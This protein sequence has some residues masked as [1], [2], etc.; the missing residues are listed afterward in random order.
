MNKHQIAVGLFIIMLGGLFWSRAVLS[1]TQGAWVLFALW[2]YRIWWPQ[3]TKDTLLL[4]SICPIGLFLL[5]W[6]QQPYALVNYDLL[7]TFTV[8]P[9]VVL[10][11]RSVSDG[12]IKH[13]INI[14]QWAA[15][16]GL[17]YPLGWYLLH[18][19][20]AHTAYGAGRSLPTFMDT[21]HIRFSIFL[22][23][24]LLFSLVNKN[25]VTLR[26]KLGVAVLILCIILLSVRTAWLILFAMCLVAALLN[27]RSAKRWP[28]Y[29]WLLLL[30]LFAGISI[31]IFYL[32]PTVQ[33]KIAYTLY[34]WQQFKPGKYNPDF[35]D[36]A[37]RAINHSAFQ[38]VLA[39]GSN[40]GWAGIPDT[41]QRYFSQSFPGTVLQYGWPFNQ[42]LFWWMGSGWWGMLLFTAWLCYPFFRGWKIN[43]KGL[44]YWTAAIMVSCLVECTL[45]FQ[46]GVFL[47]AWPLALLWGGGVKKMAVNV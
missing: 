6:Y 22:C 26:N 43:N 40:T 25:T 2:Q 12:T 24:T 35:S 9:V 30:L 32:F 19:Q 1:I 21:D 45:T 34:D 15:V 39:D 38:A 33:Q 17:L 18:I 20:E 27:I 29:N 11:V 42:W 41:L 37:R 31:T 23:A 4:W 16:A 7:L 13:L 10:A 3:L 44:V 14:W 5:G 8:Y 36:G 28:V 47:H 46:Y